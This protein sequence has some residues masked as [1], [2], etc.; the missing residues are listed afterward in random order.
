M[1]P[2]L[3]LGLENAE[4]AAASTLSLKDISRECQKSLLPYSEHVLS[5]TL[6]SLK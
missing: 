6:V 2:L 4:T 5:A 1:I 3:M